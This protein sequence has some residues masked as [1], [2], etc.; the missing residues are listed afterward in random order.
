MNYTKFISSIGIFSFCML[1]SLETQGRCLC[2]PNCPETFEQRQQ[3]YH[4]NYDGYLNSR[5]Q[6]EVNNGDDGGFFLFGALLVGGAIYSAYQSSTY[7]KSQYYNR[8]YKRR[9]VPRPPAFILG[10]SIPLY[11][12]GVND[13]W[14]NGLSGALKGEFLLIGSRGSYPNVGLYVNAGHSTYRYNLP[15][16]ERQYYLGHEF[17]YEG[18]PSLAYPINPTLSEEEEV[19]KRIALTETAINLGASFKTFFSGG[20]FIDVGAGI[21]LNRQLQLRFGQE[22]SYLGSGHRIRAHKMDGIGEIENKPYLFD[23]KDTY[24]EFGLGKIFQGKKMPFHVKLTGQLFQLDY[25]NTT[26]HNVYQK[27][28]NQL[29][30]V[31]V[32]ANKLAYSIGIEMAWLFGRFT[33]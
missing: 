12:T 19:S 28:D 22:Y 1:F 25:A 30:P 4:N 16:T 33:R 27:V 29:M 31:E 9:F 2:Y 13:E 14:K 32:T 20:L 24:M 6:R 8:R 17:V 26:G 5:Q 15:F 23:L 10:G 21:K 3:R 18:D 11:K 7:H